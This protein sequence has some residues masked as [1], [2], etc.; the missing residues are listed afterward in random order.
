MSDRLTAMDVEK[1]EFRQKVR[2]Y[3]Q[4]EVR[5]FLRS[6]AEEM[7]RLNLRNAELEEDTGRLRDQVREIREREQTL[8]ET[9]VSAQRMAEEMKERATHE[10]E[11]V[12][13]EARIKAERTLEQAQ[14]QLARIEGEIQRTK[15]ERDAFENRLRSAVEDHLSMLELRRSE[16]QDLDNLH[17]MHRKTGSDAG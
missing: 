8:Q 7:Q 12:L 13:R 9:L 17:F 10:S 5:L 1:Q 15:L 6:V 14:D 4:D 3:A 11:M 16:R 2:G